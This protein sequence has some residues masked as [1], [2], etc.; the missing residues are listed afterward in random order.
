MST[1]SWTSVEKTTRPGVAWL[2]PYAVLKLLG[3][4]K[5]TVCLFVLA[6][7]IVLVGTLAQDEETLVQVK[8]EYFNAWIAWVPVDVLFP[9]TLWQHEA[10]E[11]KFPFPGGA[12]IGL[13]LLIN[14]IAAKATRF[15][16][17][18][19]GMR[20]WIGLVVSLLGAGLVTVV[21]TS[22]H[23]AD[24][25]QGRPPVSYDQLWSM[26]KL[27]MV[28]LSLGSLVYAY[29]AAQLPPLARWVVWIGV[30][31]LGTLTLMLLIGGQSMRL[32]DPGLRIVWQLLQATVASCVVLLGLILVFEKRGGNVLIHIGVALL[33][34]GQFVFGDR[35]VEQRLTLAEG[36]S[37][38]MAYTPD[39]LE[40]AMIDVS[41]SDQDHVKAIPDALIRRALRRGEP[42]DDPQL[43]C[44]VRIDQWMTNS[45]LKAVESGEN[46][47]ATQGLG[48]SVKAVEVPLRGAAQSAVNLASAYVTLIDRESQTPIATV[49][50]SQMANDR[51]QLVHGAGDRPES[52]TIGGVS[53]E[54]A[55]RFRRDYKNYRLFLE[56]V[57]RENY[58]GSETPR[59]YSSVIRIRNELTGE[60]IT[61]KTWMNNPVRFG[62]ETFYQ[63]NYE[64]VALPDGTM[65]EV[66]GLQVVRNAGWMIP[67][68]CCMMV[69][70]GMVSHFG[71]TFVRYAGKM[72]REERGAVRS[73]WYKAEWFAL[74]VGLALVAVVAGYGLRSQRFGVNQVDWNLVG[75]LPVLHEGRIKPADTVAANLLQT[76]SEPIFG[77]RPYVTDGQE[78]KRPQVE[79]LLSVMAD[80]PWTQEA[81]VF[82]VYSK[83]VRDLL[84][85][86]ERPGYRYSY[87]EMEP[88]REQFFAEVD[89]LR[90]KS[91]N[92][93]ELNFREQKISEMYQK[94]TT[95][96]LL[97]MA[98]QQPPLPALNNVDSD[99]GFRKALM[100]LD[101][102][103]QRYKLV[104]SMHPPAFI[105]PV[106][107]A[108]D[109][110]QPSE[111][112]GQS[113]NQTDAGDNNSSWSAF[114]PASFQSLID[115]VRGQPVNPA[116][117]GFEQVL[118]AL[119]KEDARE[120]N[121]AF[122]K[123]QSQISELATVQPF[124]LK[125]SLEQ[126]LNHFNPTSLGIVLYLLALITGFASFG[127]GGNRLRAA[128]FGILLGVFVIH[129]V[130]LLL[131]MY[132]SGRAP[133]TNLY[134]SAV[135][136]GW[137]CVLFCLILE[138]VYRLGVAN[139]V[140]G[141]I[142]AITLCIARGLDKGD[143]MHVLAAVLD[144]QFWLS[145]HV[146][147]VT[148]GYAV[149]YLAG[150]LG[151]VALVYMMLGRNRQRSPAEDKASQQVLQTLYR[152]A[153]FSVCFGLLFSFVG[154]VL[155][156]LWADDSW[157]RF[158]GWDPKE[159]GALMIVL[160]NAL[161][162][163]ARWDKMVGLRGF[164]ILALIGNIVTS[165]SWFGTN[166]LGI[167]L[168]NY[169]F[170]KSV[171]F[172]LVVTLIVHTVFIA[173][174]L[175]LTTSRP[176]A[177]SE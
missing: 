5:I 14:L 109:P 167:G 31:L 8:R 150:F 149:T 2:T 71:G 93:E 49:L 120:V 83:E 144:T 130:G 147:T 4:L 139:I 17:H 48:L 40:I 90:E 43:P 118:L 23:T 140:A 173:V 26:L 111:A 32:D 174:A 20:L 107:E 177:S 75:R 146:V 72:A 74:L 102:L 61:E 152:M 132:I 148:L 155:G 96:E 97:T 169:G 52:I 62:G 76:L 159:N 6:I 137:A 39:E 135:F 60:E 27:G 16:I 160:W 54:L 115:Q 69:L 3:S 30:F 22:G 163:H 19:K 41:G 123:Y 154:T 66:S 7:V 29:R 141:L 100:E 35:Q 162:L 104:R 68:V 33:M 157:G 24:G 176:R 136:I 95:Y 145:T 87:R 65:T 114:G 42:I 105:P 99:E 158:W 138:M 121:S 106:A 53:Y 47:P 85:L 127:F 10:F 15:S 151:A 79:W 142:G 9:Q 63:S 38:N 161:M 168:H 81:P 12:L 108:T 94:F 58:S 122:K 59:D 134:S 82:R 36:Q 171:A 128:T 101:A 80:L 170:N 1:A 25:L 77:G 172:A 64:K 45:A 143:T 113:K 91:R 126:W 56:D 78:V 117:A 129:T 92:Q 112:E 34:V 84:G 103:D 89:K 165:W 125:A 13:A 98:Y 70:V 18:A 119:Q 88:R 46:N 73:T 131:R 28:F 153:Y 156:G 133:V 21:I 11:G 124:V 166:L 67:Y 110:S 55:L 164:S 175:S 57:V 44:V 37:S 50:L 86:E 51:Q 116:V